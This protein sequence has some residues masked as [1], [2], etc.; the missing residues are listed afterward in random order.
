MLF[1]DPVGFST[2][3]LPCRQP[4]AWS[5][6]LYAFSSA[7]HEFL[8]FLKKIVYFVLQFGEEVDFSGAVRPVESS[9]LH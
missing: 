1:R 6:M 4:L 3:L 8:F 7:F 2:F 9:V 5:S